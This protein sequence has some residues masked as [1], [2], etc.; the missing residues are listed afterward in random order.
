MLI[1]AN[2]SNQ[3]NLRMSKKTIEKSII[4]LKKETYTELNSALI[5]LLE[6]SL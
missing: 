4:C 1:K 3:E 5:Y 2:L 6:N